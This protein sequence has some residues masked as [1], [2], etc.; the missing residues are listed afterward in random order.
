MVLRGIWNLFNKTGFSV[1]SGMQSTIKY[2]LKK[3]VS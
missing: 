1:F 2:I 3:P